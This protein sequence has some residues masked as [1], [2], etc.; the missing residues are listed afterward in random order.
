MIV[1]FPFYAGIMGIMEHSGLLEIVSDWFV[2]FSAPATYPFWAL[3]LLT[4]TLLPAGKV[5]GYS[6]VVMVYGIAVASL[7][8][9]FL[10]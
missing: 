9:S 1:R 3:P 8:I 4:L 6:A 2:S 10:S 5:L 7:C